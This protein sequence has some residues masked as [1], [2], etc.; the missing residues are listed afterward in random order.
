M[1]GGVGGFGLCKKVLRKNTYFPG[2]ANTTNHSHEKL[3]FDR[4]PASL[5]GQWMQDSTGR[6]ICQT[7]Y[8]HQA[9]SRLTMSA[10]IRVA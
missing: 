6:Q 4:T 8:F 3:R 10:V 1:G 9:F 5:K 2:R 7:P